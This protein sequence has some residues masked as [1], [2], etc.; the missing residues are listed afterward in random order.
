MTGS[1][2]EEAADAQG[3]REPAPS[4][5]GGQASNRGRASDGER[6]RDQRLSAAE[7]YC[8]RLAK[9]HYENFVVASCLLPKA[10]RQPFYNLYA[11]CRHADDLADESES[12][13]A[14]LQ[15]LSDWQT[16]LDR[17]FAGQADHPIFIA[18]GE[19]ARSLK[20]NQAPLN[21]LLD[22]FR[23]DQT[24]TRYVNFEELLDYC[25]RSANPVGRIVLRM[26]KADSPENVDLS[27]SICTGLQLANHW[28]DLGRDF[29]AG[30]LYLPRDALESFG[31]TEAM[32]AHDR[33]S[34]PLKRLVFAQCYVAREY[35]IRGMPLAERVPDWLAAD[36][37]LFIH[38]GLATLDAIAAVDHDTLF[39]RPTVS[40]W[41]QFG[42]TLRAIWGRL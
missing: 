8:R 2:K 5:N 6:R 40:R 33:A 24:K 30:R 12:P 37:R 18:L 3:N 26:A 22:A 10:M 39:R 27:D 28:Q 13:A 17:C 11:F 25:R 29:A 23:Q 31:V 15:K 1:W 36:I 32:L 20:L 9:S 19:T 42:L 14:A 21:D 34:E 16:E 41:K 7:K 38:G 4:S 35:L